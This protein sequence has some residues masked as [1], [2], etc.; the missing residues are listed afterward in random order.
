MSQSL[1]IVDDEEQVRDVMTRFFESAQFE[2]HNADNVM[3]A[4]KVMESTPVDVI[5]SDYRMPGMTGIELLRMVKQKFPDTI[6]ILFTAYADLDVAICAINEGEVFRLFTK[7]CSFSELYVA[8][9]QALEKKGKF[10]LTKSFE[11]GNKTESSLSN[12][13]DNQ[14]G[15]H[16]EIRLTRSGYQIIKGANGLAFGV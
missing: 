1:L 2:T 9:Q 5:I 6:R 14:N 13:T 12:K 7:P 4:L 11:A 10:I 8:V 3:E 15:D 16:P